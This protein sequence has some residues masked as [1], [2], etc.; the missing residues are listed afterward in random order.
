MKRRHRTAILRALAL[1][2]FVLA[3]LYAGRDNAPRCN[4]APG[5]HPEFNGCD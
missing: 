2:A 3:I 4:P 1:I 5:W